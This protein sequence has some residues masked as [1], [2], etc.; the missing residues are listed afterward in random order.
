M[1]RPRSLI[2]ALLACALVAPLAAA[3]PASAS[4]GQLNYFEAGTALLEPS[5]RKKA[6]EQM[7]TL[8]VHAL[9]VELYWATVVPSRSSATQP[10]NYKAT[11][12][13][14]YDWSLYDPI[15]AEAARLHMQVLLTV[16]SPVPR[17]ATADRK[18]P[19]VTRPG[20]KAFEEFMTAVARHY[21]AEVSAWSI[22]N[23]PNHPA[24]LRPQW[25]ANGTPASP[26]VYRGLYQAGY[27]GLQAGGLPHPK[28]L[29][30][31]TAPVG[32]SSVNVR[33]EGRSALLH[34]VAPL[35]FLRSALCLSG[36]YHRAGSCG[37]LPVSGYAHH[38]YTLP[39]GPYYVPANRDSVTIGALSRLSVALDRA[40]RAGAIPAHVPIYLTEFGVQSYP[41]RELGVPVS[42]QA[43]FDAIAEHIAW[44]NGRVAAF[45]QYLLR[46]DPLGGAPGSSVHGGRV[47]FQTGL[48]YV[49]GRPKPLYYGWP[50][51]LTVT[52]RGHS[53][54]LWG[55][56]RPAAGATKVT[57]LVRR[58]GSRSYRVLKTLTTNAGGYWAFS[59]S[60][61]GQLWRVRWKSP[62]GK[63]YEGP[64]IRA[65]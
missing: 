17:W 29:F 63:T 38:A 35:T 47:G 37:R 31:E 54:A 25:N 7:Q 42:R 13:A 6:F 40:A 24:F 14:T 4:H 57:V 15:M 21:G 5:K 32:Y 34:D 36:S 11:D 60:T 45:S 9:R 49:N 39:V 64:P 50:L 43:E 55:L 23:E 62:A 8:G 61:Q 28:V 48:E 65:F 20:D 33:R 30:G 46:D 16:T 3:A 58:K 41:N 44:S 19:Y 53:F 52:R 26:R 59:S 18:A 1:P 51:P 56:V 10:A 2:I 12:P 22:W 27:A